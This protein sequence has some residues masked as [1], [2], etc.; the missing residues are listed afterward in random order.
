MTDDLRA[1][2]IKR[3]RGMI[4]VDS[5]G[6]FD[7]ELQAFHDALASAPPPGPK[8]TDAT[9]MGVVE[10]IEGCLRGESEVRVPAQ[11]SIRS[12]CGYY[13]NTLRTALDR[14]RKEAAERKP[15]PADSWTDPGGINQLRMR[16][17]EAAVALRDARQALA[18]AQREATRKVRETTEAMVKNILNGAQPDE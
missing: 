16:V 17:S 13:A 4:D 6:E 10:R 15:A 11:E 18:K 12:V 5:L 2:F 1:A 14:A 9:L 3:V 7:R 8:A